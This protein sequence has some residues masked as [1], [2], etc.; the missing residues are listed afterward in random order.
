MKYI[1]ELNQNIYV[2]Q[3]NVHKKRRICST[4]DEINVYSNNQITLLSIV[5]EGTGEI[6]GSICTIF[7]YMV[8]L[9]VLYI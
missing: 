4:E 9:G 7:G 5:P 1:T 8:K 3:K 2:D 6:G